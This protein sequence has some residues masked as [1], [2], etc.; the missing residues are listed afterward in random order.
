MCNLL[1]M[2]LLDWSARCWLSCDSWAAETHL[3]WKLGCAWKGRRSARWPMPKQG[4]TRDWLEELLFLLC[5]KLGREWDRPAQS[6]VV[7]SGCGW[8]STCHSP[9]S[10][11]FLFFFLNPYIHRAGSKENTSRLELFAFG[12]RVL[13]WV[14]WVGRREDMRHAWALGWTKNCTWTALSLFPTLVACFWHLLF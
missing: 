4:Q 12:P 5:S 2:M 8:A 6:W 7:D 14:K 3:G 1:G 10:F 13:T 9:F 11:Y